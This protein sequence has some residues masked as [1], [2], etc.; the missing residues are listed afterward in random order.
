MVS[1]HRHCHAE[2]QRTRGALTA[3]VQGDPGDVQGLRRTLTAMNTMYGAPAD[4]GHPAGAPD[5]HSARFRTTRWRRWGVGAAAFGFLVGGGIT[6]A[7]VSGG[8]ARHPARR[9]P[10]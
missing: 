10:S 2:R 8:G 7:V 4:G 6:L 3:A 1:N 5:P 9:R